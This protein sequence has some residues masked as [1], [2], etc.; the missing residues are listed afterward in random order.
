MST[1][2]FFVKTP[3]AWLPVVMSACALTL[4]Y[5]WVLIFGADPAGDEGGAAHIWQILMVLQ[6]AAVLFF[7]V[8]YLPEKP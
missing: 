3:A 1:V 2:K 5:L 4:P 6:I 7:A 8:R